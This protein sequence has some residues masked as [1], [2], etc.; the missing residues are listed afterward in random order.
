MPRTREGGSA[1][2]GNQ[3]KNDIG[4]ETKTFLQ[5]ARPQ[6]GA[7][8]VAI[9][10]SPVGARPVPALAPLVR[11]RAQASRRSAIL[12]WRHIEASHQQ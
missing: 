7:L 11:G 4:R 3:E 8:A 6:G 10:R 2:S 9:P 1:R 12:T 5:N